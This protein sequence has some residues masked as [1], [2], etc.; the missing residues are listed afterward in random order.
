MTYRINLHRVYRYKLYQRPLLEHA[1]N[2]KKTLEEEELKYSPSKILN[3][4][5]YI[6]RTQQ[7]FGLVY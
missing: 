1:K 6:E 3:G 5:G 7:A 2:W 4:A